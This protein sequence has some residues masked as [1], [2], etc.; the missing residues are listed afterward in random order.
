MF[1][2]GRQAPLGHVVTQ[3][4]FLRGGP[5]YVLFLLNSSLEI[6]ILHSTQFS[7]IYHGWK[8]KHEDANLCFSANVEHNND[9]DNT[10]FRMVCVWFVRRL[11][12]ACCLLCCDDTGFHNGTLVVLIRGLAYFFV[13]T[14]SFWRWWIKGGID[15]LKSTICIKTDVYRIAPF[16]NTTYVKKGPSAL[17]GLAPGIPPLWG[18]LMQPAGCLILK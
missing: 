7:S 8:I 17:Q 14:C 2:F 5:W 13:C 4:P 3:G 1:F 12:I 10:C 9:R 16:F 15:P 6:C 18:P 11:G